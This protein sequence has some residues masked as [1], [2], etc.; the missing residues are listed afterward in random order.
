MRVPQNTRSSGSVEVVV[1]PAMTTKSNGGR[2]SSKQRQTRPSRRIDLPLMVS[3]EVMRTMSSPSRS[4]QTGATWGLPSARVTAS[5]AVRAGSSPTKSRHQPSGASV[6][7][8]SVAGPDQ[9][10]VEHREHRGRVEE[11]V[12]AGDA[13]VDDL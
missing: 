1:V 2:S 3:A 13:P 10:E 11:V 12:D 9:R 4:T 8:T 6:Y 7:P 5:L